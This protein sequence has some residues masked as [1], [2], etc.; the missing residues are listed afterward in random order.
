[1]LLFCPSTWLTTAACLLC[2]GP[3][4]PAGAAEGGMGGLL[5][6]PT[7][8]VMEA[9]QHAA[10]LTL[11]NRGTRAATY[12]LEVVEKRMAADG[13]L[14]NLPEGE[15]P[16]HSAAALLRYSPRQV[17]LAPGETQKVRLMARRPA[18]LAPGE[19]RSHLMLRALPPATEPPR[20]QAAVG[21]G[22]LSVQLITTTAITIPL[23][24]RHGATRC[25]VELTELALRQPGNPG[26]EPRLGFR[27]I[28]SGT[29]S[30]YGDVTVEW[31]AADGRAPL[32]VGH[33]RGLAVYTPNDFRQADVPLATAPEPL[34]SG[35]LRV[36]YRDA[37]ESTRSILAERSLLLD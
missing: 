35:V 31:Q 28:R 30:S 15:A 16:P 1:M 27:I 22:Q 12:R 29:R 9:R 4:S 37:E 2:T 11:M 7:R 23:I 14:E 24:V 3:L 34:T 20:A 36:T 33:L 18:E 17:T 10:E 8:V 21:E 5:I 13:R 32:P 25:Q 6:A 19:Y 26:D